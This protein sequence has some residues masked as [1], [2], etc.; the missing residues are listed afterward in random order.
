[1]KAADM[2]LTL[3]GVKEPSVWTLSGE[4]SLSVNEI[5][6]KAIKLL[7]LM[8]ENYPNITQGEMDDI[9]HS[10]VWWNTF[11]GSFA[12]RPEPNAEAK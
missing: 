8:M 7:K 5:D 6:A 10:A 4:I 2:M 12:K 3:L 11:F 9:L 1:M